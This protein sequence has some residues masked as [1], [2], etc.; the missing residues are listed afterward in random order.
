MRLV[1]LPQAFRVVIPPLVGNYVASAK[2]TALAS[3]ISIT[4]LLKA[5]LS[6]EGSA[7][8]SVP[9][10]LCR[11]GL[12]DAVCPAHSVCQLSGAQ[13]E[14]EPAPVAPV[15]STHSACLEVLVG[16]AP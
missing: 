4:E 10:D 2:D 5:G 13:D 1:V 16:A 15:V 3:A 6:Q 9:A 7:G 14:K 8:Q 11:R 12:L